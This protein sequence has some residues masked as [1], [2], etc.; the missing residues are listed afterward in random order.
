MTLTYIAQL[1]Q[2]TKQILR[3]GEH[4]ESFYLHF[5]QRLHETLHKTHMIA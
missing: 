4:Q 1:V 5:L 2:I 3:F